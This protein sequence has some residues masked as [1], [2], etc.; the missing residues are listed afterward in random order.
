MVF[1]DDIMKHGPLSDIVQITRNEA[2]FLRF[3]PPLIVHELTHTL[4]NEKSSFGFDEKEHVPDGDEDLTKNETKDDG[5]F[6]MSPPEAKLKS[7]VNWTTI[8]FSNTTRKRI[9]LTSRESIE[10]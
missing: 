2:N 4:L 1:V 6:I 8:K 3:V 7:I 10:R 5:I 9:D